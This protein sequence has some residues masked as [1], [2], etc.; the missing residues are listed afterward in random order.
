M[1]YALLLLLLTV[2]ASTGCSMMLA[3]AGTHSSEFDTREKA[4]KLFGEPINSG[5]IE[6]QQ[7]EEFF[8]RRKFAAGGG[9]EDLAKFIYT[10]GLNELYLFPVALVRLTGTT[11]IGQTIRL[12]YDE[13]GAVKIE[14]LELGRFGTSTGRQ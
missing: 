5:S 10:L 12:I 14:Q 7:F 9:L 1:R 3:E 11:L 2:F 13:K 8:T 4:H 6:G